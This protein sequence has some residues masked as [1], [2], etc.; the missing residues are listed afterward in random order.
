MKKSEDYIPSNKLKFV[1]WLKNFVKKVK[2]H[3]NHYGI[4]QEEIKIIEPQADDFYL[5]VTTEMDLLNQKLAQFK[6]TNKDRKKIE[7]NCRSIA[8]KIKNDLNYTDD[9]GREFDIIG[10]ERQI[11]VDKAKPVLKAKKVPHG[12]EFSFGLDDYFNGVN[13]YRK[14]PDEQD[15]AYLATDTHSPYVDNQKMV[16]GTQ[17]F[18]YFIIGDTEVGLESDTVTIKV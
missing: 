8:Q 16:N 15:F 12:W 13:I 5:D 11:D 14:R 17:Y 4:N 3:V 2:K 6:K 10:D 18:A 7:K 1:A 9:I